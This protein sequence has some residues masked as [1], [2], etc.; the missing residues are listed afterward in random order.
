MPRNILPNIHLQEETGTGEWHTDHGSGGW[1]TWNLCNGTHNNHWSTVDALLTH[2]LN[3]DNF[4][5]GD[6]DSHHGSDILGLCNVPRN[7][8]RNNLWEP[9]WNN[10]LVGTLGFVGSVKNLAFP[11]EVGPRLFSVGVNGTSGRS[12]GTPGRD[13]APWCA[14][15]ARATK[16][17]T[18]ERRSTISSL[19]H[20]KWRWLAW[21]TSISWR[22][23]V[24]K[25]LSSCEGST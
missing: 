19:K 6:W 21:H 25:T 5:P 11:V 20:A 9:L 24:R 17:D 7:T 22:I 8:E 14:W 4:V 16:T 1:D 15:G 13:S 10:L 3:D 18:C 23:M 2:T 12:G